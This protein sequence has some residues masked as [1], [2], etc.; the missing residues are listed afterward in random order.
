MAN[1]KERNDMS[2]HWYD[3][4]GNPHHWIPKKDGS[5]NRATTIADARR[6]GWLPSV[7]G[8]LRVVNKP[9]LERWKMLQACT[10]VLTSPRKDGEG[11]DRFM[12]RVLFE[13][14]EHKA[15]AEA[16]ASL[17]TDIHD[18]IGLALQGKPFEDKFR[19]YVMSV[20]PIVET[21]GKIVWIEK[22]VVGEGYAGRADALVDN[23]RNV[24]L[25]DWKSTK[26]LPKKESWPDHVLQTSA[27]AKAV[28]NVGDRH[29]LTGNIYIST[30]RPGES[31]FFIQEDWP[32]T[33]ED[34]FK[35]LLK[36]WQWSNKYNP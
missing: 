10:A 30:S 21:L 24:V 3:V 6:E 29:I 25:L 32:T 16:A 27:Y 18:A 35:P 17:G 12:E 8:I 11:L 13:D 14:E 5:G 23:D 36:F 31:A 28:G 22:V 34:G 9:Q 26:N 15:E 2:E 4:E 1:K 7:S 19:P 20:F 33:F